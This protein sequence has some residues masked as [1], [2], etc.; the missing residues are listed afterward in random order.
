MEIEKLKQELSEKYMQA[1][2][3]RKSKKILIDTLEKRAIG[4]HAHQQ[5][6]LSDY[7]IKHKEK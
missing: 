3:L 5:R 4:I 2:G 7:G 6:S 1:R